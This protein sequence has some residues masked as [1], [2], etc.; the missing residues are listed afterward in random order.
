NRF[1][2]LRQYGKSHSRRADALNAMGVP[3]DKNGWPDVDHNGVLVVGNVPMPLPGCP[4]L[5]AKTAIGLGLPFSLLRMKRQIGG[6][7]Q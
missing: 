2:W 1:Y 6:R 3:L 5:Y 7:S 4:G